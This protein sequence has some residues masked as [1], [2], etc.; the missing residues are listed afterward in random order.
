MLNNILHESNFLRYK[1][2]FEDL[3]YKDFSSSATIHFF[4]ENDK[5]ASVLKLGVMTQE[6]IFRRIE[7]NEI[8]NLNQTYISNFSLSDYRIKKGLNETETVILN[9]FSAK[10]AF[11]DC[12]LITDFS[13]AD[14][15]GETTNFEGCIFG[16]NAVTFANARFLGD[17]VMFKN[18]KFGT[19]SVSFQSVSM[20]NGL[21]SFNKVNFGKGNLNFVDANF[22]HG[23]VDFKNAIFGEGIVDFKFAKFLI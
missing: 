8:L 14:F 4:D 2:V 9:N 20:G 5:V 3:P 23:N 13:Y 16:N 15:S 19:G 21:V 22:G 7:N 17:D 18:S 1:V 10:K 12:E 11:F 6:E